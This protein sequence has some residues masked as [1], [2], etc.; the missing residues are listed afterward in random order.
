MC[1][2]GFF[3]LA[4]IC[5]FQSKH[6]YSIAMSSLVSLK[7]KNKELLVVFTSDLHT[8]G[9]R[10][11]I[12]FEKYPLTVLASVG[13]ANGR[14]NAASWACDRKRVSEAL[15]GLTD[16]TACWWRY[17]SDHT[18]ADLRGGRERNRGRAGDD[19]RVKVDSNLENPS[20][21]S[22]SENWIA[23]KANN[24]TVCV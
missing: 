18:T 19:E 24:E 10:Q 2:K 14:G 12:W 1:F 11:T 9:I 21:E 3:V 7:L 4:S 20:Q 13:S 17:V 8:F 23:T 5:W 16:S 22:Q 6:Q 15:S